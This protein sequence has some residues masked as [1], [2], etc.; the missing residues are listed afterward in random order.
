MA[1][2]ITSPLELIG[3]VQLASRAGADNLWCKKKFSQRDRVVVC[4]VMRGI[5][6]RD[7]ALARQRTHRLEHFRVRAQLL[8]VAL[9][10]LL[11][12]RR[13]VTEPL[14]QLRTGREFLGPLIQ[15]QSL[16]LDTSRPQAV[17][18]YTRTVVVGWGLVGALDPDVPGWNFR[19]HE[20][21]LVAVKLWR[22][23]AGRCGQR[24]A[25]DRGPSPAARRVEMIML[26]NFMV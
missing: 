6:E 1:L 3:V 11:P 13:V 18:Q 8:C 4:F 23:L 17:N 19:A 7:G 21:S 16:L 15:C 10:K 9:A 12:A 22:S 5:H 20:D 26:G 25:L 2:S 24:C 14:A